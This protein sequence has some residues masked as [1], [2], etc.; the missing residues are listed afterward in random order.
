MARKE[1][2]R[3]VDQEEHYASGLGLDPE[4]DYGR[5]VSFAGVVVSIPSH[6]SFALSNLSPLHL[7]RYPY[8]NEP[9]RPGYFENGNKEPTGNLAKKARTDP[10]GGWEK[11][12][13]ENIRQA[14]VEQLRHPTQGLEDVIRAHFYLRQKGIL[15]TVEGWLTAAKR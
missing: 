13:V 10:N 5:E 15:K 6:L 2:Q 11:L 3:R 9:G 12:R 4:H 14:M 7:P 1:C 8:F